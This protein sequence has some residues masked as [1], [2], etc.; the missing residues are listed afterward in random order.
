MLF[1]NTQTGAKAHVL[2]VHGYRSHAYAPPLEKFSERLFWRGYNIFRFDL[3]CHGPRDSL[4][5]VSMAGHVNAKAYLDRTWRATWKVLSKRP[6]LPIFFIGESFGSVL[7][8]RILQTHPEIIV[9]T[10]GVVCIG[11][12]FSVDHN[13]SWWARM[14]G[15]IILR[16]PFLQS[17]L[18][19]IPVSAPDIPPRVKRKAHDGC[20]E[21]DP[22]YVTGG[23]RLCSA[24]A[25]RKTVLEVKRDMNRLE[26]VQKLFIHG[27]DDKVAPYDETALC[28][29]NAHVYAMF[30]VG[31]HVLYEATDEVAGIIGRWMD[32]AVTS[33][34][35]TV[36]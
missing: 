27:A 16:S 1:E 35:T 13:A 3:P 5:D 4:S 21:N 8:C 7:M 9:R 29:G 15:T 17:A 11:M 25:I 32:T 24:L 2:I 31:H 34:R 30:G 22:L 33:V 19:N 10:K 6:R 28:A 14:A 36:T 18:A 20:F 12:P 26:R 23:T